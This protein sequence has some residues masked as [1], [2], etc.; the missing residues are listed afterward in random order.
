MSLND[1]N[2]GENNVPLTPEFLHSLVRTN[3]LA[4]SMVDW[5]LCMLDS[6]IVG[7]FEIAPARN[8]FS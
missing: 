6:W 5:R 1:E 7:F 4:Q 2:T 3:E 8:E